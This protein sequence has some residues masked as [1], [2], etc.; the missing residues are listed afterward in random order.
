[1]VGFTTR[2]YQLR[3][4]HEAVLRETLES[5]DVQHLVARPFHRVGR[6]ARANASTTNCG[7]SK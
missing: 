1:M 4:R 6:D 5:E 3:L 2:S 7:R